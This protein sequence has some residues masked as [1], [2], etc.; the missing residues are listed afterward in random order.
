MNYNPFDAKHFTRVVQSD[1]NQI[2]S[3]I[4]KKMD[5]N[6]FHYLRMYKDGSLL[7]LHNRMD[8]ND[9][10]YENNFKTQVPLPEEQIIKYGKYNLCLC[11]NILSDKLAIAR[12]ACNFDHPLA[13]SVAHKDYFEVFAFATHHGNNSVL[14]SYLNQIESIIN[15]TNE[16]KDKA[17]N[18]I[19]KAENHRAILPQDIHADELKILDNLSE[20]QIVLGNH[21]PVKLTFREIETLSLLVKGLTGKEIAAKF[22]RSIRTV[23]SYINNLKDKF[24]CNRKSQLVQLALANNIF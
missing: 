15:F 8:W 3:P 17:D 21:G 5:L 22:C 19:K 4:F 23:E 16:F 18:L 7:A 6:Y 9:Y 14:N 12:T 24:G 20:A 1:I 13:I 10:F 2:C 11:D